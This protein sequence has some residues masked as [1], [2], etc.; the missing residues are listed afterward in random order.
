MEVTSRWN[1]GDDRQ[2]SLR[3]SAATKWNGYAQVEIPYYLLVDRDPMRA[4]VILYAN[5]DRA[6]GAYAHLQSWEFGET[7]RLP[8]PFG[9]VIATDDWEPWR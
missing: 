9:V 7:V 3:R 6:A 8:E 1:A 2:P 5:P 4:Q